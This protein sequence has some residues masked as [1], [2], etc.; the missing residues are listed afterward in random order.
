MTEYVMAG[1]RIGFVDLHLDNFHA[2]VYLSLVRG[3]LADRGWTVAGCCS[4]SPVDGQEWAKANDVPWF[5][6]VEAMNAE[7][8]AF[9]VLAPSNPEVHL[10]LCEMTLPF[11]KPTYVDKTFAPDLATA[12][13]IFALGAEHG[14]EVQT[15]SALRYT[16]V[17]DEVKGD[18]NDLQHMVAW[19]GGGSFGEYA[20]HP[21]ELVVSCMG[22]DATRLMRRGTGDKSQLL[23]DF[24]DGRT[25]VINV[26]VQ[27]DTPFAASLTT[28][29]GTQYLAVEDG[30]IFLNQMAAIIDFFEAGV[31]QTDKAE[32]LMIRKILDAADNPQALEQF[33][34]L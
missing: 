9:M 30:K 21:T 33:I 34:N 15:S 14:A 19:G 18:D 25:A 3:D 20:I 29:A 16:N 22:A 1:K 12:E 32:S 17:Q 5:D 2:N 27:S 6:S 28:T 4:T 26:Y 8:D 31:A 10:E 7:V 11:G 13:K 23:V 24:S